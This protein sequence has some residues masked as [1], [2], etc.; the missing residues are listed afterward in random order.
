M[1]TDYFVIGFIFYYKLINLVANF[2]FSS[3]QSILQTAPEHV[4]VSARQCRVLYK[5]PARTEY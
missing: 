5:N 1:T 2:A 3:P 4:Y